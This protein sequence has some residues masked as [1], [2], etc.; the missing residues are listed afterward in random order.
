MHHW[1]KN[2]LV[3]APA[4]LAH[5]DSLFHD[6]ARSAVA[7]AAFCLIASATYLVND[8][9]D[10]AHDRAHP[11]KRERP[12]AAGAISTATAMRV[13]V[14]FA[15]AGF[16]VASLVGPYVVATML[17]YLAITITYTVVLKR[18][19]VADVMALA[20]LYVLRFVAGATAAPVPMS[21]WFLAF[22]VFLFTSLGFAKRATEIT[23]LQIDEAEPAGRGYRR[24]DTGVLV[25][26]GCAAGYTAVLVFALYINSP[27]IHLLYRRPDILWLA[28]F[29]LM[30][31]LSRVWLLA[32]RGALG[33]D[34]IDFAMRDPVSIA[35]GVVCAIAMAAARFWS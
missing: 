23:S 30:G 20:A 29:A 8:A 9:F 17:G 3:F 13:A 33:D 34:P 19:A 25:A 35:L 28:A 27:D 32:Q 6:L 5:R 10:L 1:S 15:V 11:R 26:L 2:L 16:S 21:A 24:S 18:F 4:I 7:F 31:W 12:L 14:V 22:S